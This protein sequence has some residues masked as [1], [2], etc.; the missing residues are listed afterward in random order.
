MRPIVDCF[1]E[2]RVIVLSKDPHFFG[3]NPDVLL[4]VLS[5]EGPPKA[6]PTFED[7]LEVQLRLGALKTRYGQIALFSFLVRTYSLINL[8]RGQITMVSHKNG[9]FPFK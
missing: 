2:N 7:Y 8:H 5:E 3:Q 9:N 1:E 6:L 4:R